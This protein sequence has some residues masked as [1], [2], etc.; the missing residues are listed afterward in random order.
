MHQ[1]V[2]ITAAAALAG[3]LNGAAAQSAGPAAPDFYR[4]KTISILIGAPPGGGFDLA[5]RLVAR[6]LGR[7]IAGQPGFIP[8]NMPGAS[9]VRVIDYLFNVAPHDGTTIGITLPSSYLS[10]VLDSSEGGKPHQ[11]TWV[12]R[13]AAFRG[14]GVVWKDVP[15]KN[16]AE[17][18]QRAVSMGAEGP[19]GLAAVTMSALNALGGSKF[20]IVKG[21]SGNADQ[22][23]A[24]QR[25]EIQG[26]GSL[27]WEYIDSL[28][29]VKQDKIRFIF[30][31]GLSRYHRIP[32]VPTVTELID[33][34]DD[35]A[36][37]RLIA[38][39]TEIG[40][41]FV[42][43]PGIPQDR[44]EILRQA[45]TA[46][47]GNQEFRDDAEKLKLELEPLTG[48]E[49]QKLV[50]SAMN[51]SQKVIDRTRDFMPGLK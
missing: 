32:D 10:K 27:S 8:Q 44:T 21:Y 12:G 37:I 41:A 40:R 15:I 13:L 34:E 29:W 47:I 48:A 30:N 43:P 23:L 2:F 38:S 42:G 4:G 7:Q 18:K 14:Y 35:K 11:M 22:G 17:A 46:M 33:N 39:S 26:S 24:M 1:R 36:V 31:I 51:T 49:M 6:H 19:T 45:F 5:A 3:M 25:G 50:T 16:F 20:N 28:D 9:G